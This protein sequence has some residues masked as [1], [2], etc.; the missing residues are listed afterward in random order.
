MNV[1]KDKLYIN[2]IISG[3]K[4]FRVGKSF[5]VE[6]QNFLRCDAKCKINNVG[7]DCYETYAVNGGSKLNVIYIFN[8]NNFHFTFF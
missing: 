2:Y 1:Q 7:Y 6:L 5:G 3:G 8:G 4:C